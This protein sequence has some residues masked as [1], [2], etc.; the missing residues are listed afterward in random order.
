M[1]QEDQR[2]DGGKRMEGV[3]ESLQP[4]TNLKA[5]TIESYLGAKFPFWMSSNTVLSNL[6]VKRIG[7]EFYGFGKNSSSSSVANSVQQPE[8]VFS[9]LKKL[10][11]LHMKEC[12][13]WDL[14]FE[15]GKG[16]FPNLR[17]VLLTGCENLQRLP[18][19]G[20]LKSLEELEL[21][22]LEKVKCL[23]LE[24]LR[25]TTSV[26]ASAEVGELALV[27]AVFPELKKLKLVNMLAWEEQEE[28]I[29]RV[30]KKVSPLSISCLVSV[31]Y[32]SIYVQS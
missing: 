10:K 4:H 14:P 21:I 32:A 26:D 25:I 13:E 12:E 1:G 23:G 28:M 15:N 19:L 5:L 18:A 3:L 9:K 17:Q 6:S 8:V 22:R 27:I 16:I 29:P 11:I 7:Y 31:P 20:R 30:V 2:E 24:F